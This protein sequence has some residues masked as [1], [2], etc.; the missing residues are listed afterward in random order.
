MT[1]IYKAEKQCKWAFGL[2]PTENI[3]LIYSSNYLP[4]NG[5]WGLFPEIRFFNIL[6]YWL[7]NVQ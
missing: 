4:E 7:K 6:L 2:S 1:P 5:Y 3:I